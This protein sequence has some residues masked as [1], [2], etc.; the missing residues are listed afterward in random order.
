MAHEVL[1]GDRTARGHGLEHGLAVGA[2]LL[3]AD[4]HAGVLGQVHRDRVVQLQAAVFHQHHRGDRGD[5][6]A[7]RVDAEDAVTRHRGAGGRVELADRFE[8]RDLALARDQQHRAGDLAGRHVGLEHVGELLQALGGQAHRLGPGGGQRLGGGE[9][10]QGEAQAE[11][12]RAHQGAAL[13]EGHACC[14]RR[15]WKDGTGRT[16][17][18][19]SV[20][21]G[22]GAVYRWMGHRAARDQ[23]ADWRHLWRR[24]LDADNENY[25]HLSA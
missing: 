23:L 1:H 2:G 12:G 17:L 10:R 21:T 16:V 24:Y 5:G 15:W 3:D 22:R 13:Q 11:Q 7:H 9:Q 6:L 25:Y 20:R 18:T 4:R 19:P 14:L 8:P